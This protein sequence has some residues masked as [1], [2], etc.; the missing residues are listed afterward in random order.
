[1]R[2]SRPRRRPL[3]A[4]VLL[5]AIMTSASCSSSDSSTSTVT[6]L[7]PPSDIDSQL[8]HTLDGIPILV[9]VPNGGAA[10]AVL[11]DKTISDPLTD[12]GD[13]LELVRRCYYTVPSGQRIGGCVA[14][15]P[16]CPGSDPTKGGPDCCP[17]RCLSDFKAAVTGG[18]SDDVAVNTTV[19]HGDCVAGYAAFVD[20][21]S[22]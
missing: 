8:M 13:C 16:T 4:L 21:G 22:K 10:V 9:A 7:T 11:Y 20:G 3:L 19:L 15:I 5:V 2:Q 1:M 18:A 17:A 12:W 14:A 6:S